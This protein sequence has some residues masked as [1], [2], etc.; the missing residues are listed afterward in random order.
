MNELD[1][2]TLRELQLEVAR[3]L[4]CMPASN[5]NLSRFN[6]LA[7]HNSITWY[8]AVISWYI[9]EY[10]DLPSKVGPGTEVKLLYV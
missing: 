8:K 3:V 2:L 10:G 6:K 4:H 7:N 5:H 9:D 1:S